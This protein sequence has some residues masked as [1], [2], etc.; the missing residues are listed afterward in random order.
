MLGNE[1]FIPLKPF[2]VG[3]AEQAR[4]NARKRK[5]QPRSSS[6]SSSSSTTRTHHHES[7]PP[8]PKSMREYER[9][10]GSLLS[11]STIALQQ[12][13]TDGNSHRAV[14]QQACSLLNV[15]CLPTPSYLQQ[16]IDARTHHLMQRSSSI[17]INAT[18]IADSPRSGTFDNA[19]GEN[20][21]GDT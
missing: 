7:L 3:G 21:L 8:Y 13:E 1:D 16:P 4:R 15:P 11:S 9:F 17:G 2:F 6:S 12:S 10:F 5:F 19:R 18:N 20:L 14:L